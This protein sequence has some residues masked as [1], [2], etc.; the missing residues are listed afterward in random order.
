VVWP[1]VAA[2]SCLASWALTLL[3]RRC[4][5]RDQPVGFYLPLGLAAVLTVA[6][7]AALFAGPYVTGLDPTTHVYPATVW[8]LVLWS[9]LHLGVALI[10]QLYCIARRVAGRMTAEYDIDI[11]NVALYWHF[12]AITVVVTVAVIA[13]FPR[14]A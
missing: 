2:L 5:R 1:V 3:A 11:Q 8:V 14:V 10:M 4:N 13:G 7:A 6:T 12:M 9:L